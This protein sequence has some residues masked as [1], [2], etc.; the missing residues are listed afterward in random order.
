MLHCSPPLGCWL[1]NL[2]FSHNNNVLFE[3]G[4]VW[5]K[6]WFSTNWLTR[7]G[8]V[9]MTACSVLCFG[10]QQCWSEINIW[11]VKLLE[12]LLGVFFLSSQEA[13]YFFFN[14]K[15][16]LLQLGNLISGSILNLLITRL[17]CL[18]LFFPFSESVPCSVESSWA[19]L[20]WSVLKTIF[21]FTSSCLVPDGAQSVGGRGGAGGV[22]PVWGDVVPGCGHRSGPGHWWVPQTLFCCEIIE[23]PCCGPSLQA[24]VSWHLVCVLDWFIWPKVIR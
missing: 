12:S 23:S 22:R 2:N 8:A 24:V 10:S 18:A 17:T 13:P 16:V 19:K 15:S 21:P 20:K 3:V 6:N 14:Y 5:T 4:T 1:S 9:Y 11:S 7:E